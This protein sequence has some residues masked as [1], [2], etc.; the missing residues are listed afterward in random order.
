ML[1]MFL[2]IMLSSV[3]NTPLVQPEFFHRGISKVDVH[4]GVF[5]VLKKRKENLQI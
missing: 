3:L 4:T 1:Q 2:V 5:F